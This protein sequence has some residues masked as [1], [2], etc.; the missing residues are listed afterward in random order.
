MN[1]ATFSVALLALAWPIAS[2]ADTTAWRAW[3]HGLHRQCPNNHVE[4][5]PDGAYDD[6][7]GAFE[8]SLAL[9]TQIKIARIVD[10]EHRCADEQMGFSCEMATSL[11]AYRRLG[12][13]KLF[14]EFG[15]AHVKCEDDAL[16]SEFPGRATV[17][18]DSSATPQ[19]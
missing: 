14:V 18:N 16:C 10:Y 4:W 9:P 1:T 19:N 5:V 6:L 2:C 3:E 13:L 15:C 17:S 7:L 11:D 8:S 12:L